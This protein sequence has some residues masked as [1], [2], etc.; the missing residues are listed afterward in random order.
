MTDHRFMHAQHFS[1]EK[2][3]NR[4]INCIER[5]IDTKTTVTINAKHRAGYD[6]LWLTVLRSRVSP[7]HFSEE[8][9]TT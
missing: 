5:T 2:R 8:G 9:L 1:C 4:L 7:A 6:E 3:I